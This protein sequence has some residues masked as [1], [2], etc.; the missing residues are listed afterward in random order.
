MKTLIRSN[1]FAALALAVS[2]LAVA[3]HAI[4]AEYGGS[5]QPLI[6]LEGEVIDVRWVSPHVEV[7]V[8]VTGGDMP[9]GEEWTVN[10][11]APGLLARTYGIMPGE[12]S[13]GD[14]VRFVGWKSR[15]D[16]PRYHMRALSINGGPLRSTLRGADNRDI[17]N[18]TLGDI[19]PSPGLES[20][21]PLQA[22][23]E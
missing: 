20:N 3:H 8:R 18:G 11:H 4:T 19:V 2:P 16:V 1:L 5:S 7:R 17:A 10:S 23:E 21:Q 13:V 15:F 22:G 12:V 6:P 14:S 9:V